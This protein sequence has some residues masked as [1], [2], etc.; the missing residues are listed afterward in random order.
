MKTRTERNV[1]CKIENHSYFIPHL[2]KLLI[3]FF[4]LYRYSLDPTGTACTVSW[5]FKSMSYVTYVLSIFVAS[6]LLP[7]I[8]IIYCYVRTWQFIIKV[9]EGG[10]QEN[11]EWTHEKQVAKVGICNRNPRRRGFNLPVTCFDLECQLRCI[12]YRP[13]KPRCVAKHTNTH[14]HT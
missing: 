9:G 3:L 1:S 4:Y 11:I 14:T 7:G 12:S 8:V 2:Y 13:Y 10:A 5:T 6:F